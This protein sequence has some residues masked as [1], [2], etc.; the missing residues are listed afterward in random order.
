MNHRKVLILMAALGVAFGSCQDRTK[1]LRALRQPDNGV[2]MSQTHM[3][4]D[5]AFRMG[6]SPFMAAM[7]TNMQ[8]MHQMRMSGNAD[9]DLALW[10]IH[11][12]QGAVRM[13]NAELRRGTNEEMKS[14]ARKI[15]S[16]Q[17]KEIADLRLIAERH[18]GSA[19]NYDPA[20][21]STGLAKEL[22]ELMNQMMT[23]MQGM[24]M[25][26]T[27]HM[28]MNGRHP[29]S[30]MK[31]MGGRPPKDMD[32]QFGQMMKI[33]HQQGMKISGLVS[34]YSTDARFKSMAAGM[35]VS[36]EKDIRKLDAWL[37]KH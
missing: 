1:K 36:Q 26:S 10:L 13:A 28:N 5:T 12:H 35:K 27:M 14:M 33:H 21:K 31:S 25:D 7:D 15:I 30:M 18:K 17:E 2:G 34:R 24:Q 32:Y 16:R 20:D 4:A 6:R 29:D 8:Q 11:H 19:A 23:S 37:K 3:I 22:N 9:Y